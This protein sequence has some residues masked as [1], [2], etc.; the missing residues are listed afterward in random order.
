MKLA[1][2][3]F[4]LFFALCSNAQDQKLVYDSVK[5]RKLGADDNGMKR[6]V[7]VFLKTGPTQVTDSAK[8]AEL[9]A[10]HM[11]NIQ[12]LA[13]AGKLVLAGPIVKD[14]PLRGIFIF[15]VTTIEEA[16][17]L[18][19]LD[20]AVAA[21]VFEVEFHPWYASAAL[22]EINSIHKTLQKKNH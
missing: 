6:Y 13:D 9:F 16:R 22:G 19:A 11:K 17:A 14:P 12:K 1:C 3:L 10:G 21:G 15:D 18:T 5:A 4:A 20:P 8:R 7:M 2:L